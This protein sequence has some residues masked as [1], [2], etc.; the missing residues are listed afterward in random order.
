MGDTT[1]VSVQTTDQSLQAGGK[2]RKGR[3]GQ[4]P[5]T[6]TLAPYRCSLHIACRPVLCHD[7]T[8]GRAPD[9]NTED[10]RTPD[11][12]LFSVCAVVSLLGAEK[13]EGFLA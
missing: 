5:S 11:T 3:A 6:S 7:D 2:G 8:P 10:D 12:P 1:A 4:S 9:R 13:R